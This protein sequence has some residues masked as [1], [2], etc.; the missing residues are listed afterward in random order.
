MKRRSL[1]QSAVVSACLGG[2]CGISLR[3]QEQLLD[4]LVVGSGAAGLAASIEAANAGASVALIEKEGF[5]G[6]DTLVSGGFYNCPGSALQKTLGIEDSQ[7]LYLSHIRASANGKGDPRLQEVLAQN[8]LG[9]FDW[10][11]KQGVV[12]EDRVYRIYGSNYQRC[13][14]PVLARGTSYIQNLSQ[15]SLKAG[16]RILTN[17]KMLDFEKTGSTFEVSIRADGVIRQIKTKALVLCAGGFG[18][19]PDL[20]AKYVPALNFV[21]SDSRGSGEVMEKAF[22]RGVASE[23]MDAVECVP[24]GSYLN[25]Y[26]V[27]IYVLLDGLVFVNELGDRFANE[28]ASRQELSKALIAQGK[29]KCYTIVDSYNLRMLDK[30]QQKNL[31]RAYFNGQVWKSNT[32]EDLCKTISLPVDKVLS[33]IKE[34]PEENRP[35]VSPYWAVRMYPWVHYTLGGLKINEHAECLTKSGEVFEGLYAAGQLTGNLHGE[36]RLGGNGLTDA[37]VFGRIAG[38]SA[39]KYAKRA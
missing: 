37:F 6:G 11:R 28:M 15:A 39:A 35:K 38:K 33:S 4:V 5:I 32:I 26:S 1:V 25:D 22:E 24:E 27:R 10:L 23:N 3:A 31:Y 16:V 36:N 34:L 21:Y 18:N 7:E 8:A 17:S 2:T 13:H 19:N 30:M 29:K 12:F 20:I 14:K 9:T